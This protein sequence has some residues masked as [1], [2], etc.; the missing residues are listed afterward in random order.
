MRAVQRALAARV[1]ASSLVPTRAFSSSA[2]GSQLARSYA[3]KPNGERN[4]ALFLLIADS[5]VMRMK[6]LQMRDSTRYGCL[7]ILVE[8]GGCSGFSYNFDVIS[9]EQA[10]QEARED[11]ELLIFE[12]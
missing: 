2:A 8:G 4:E 11:P 5:A 6:F 3:T 1:S 9:A 12:Q 10:E 7:K